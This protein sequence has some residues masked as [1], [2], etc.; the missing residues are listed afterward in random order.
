MENPDSVRVG[1]ACDCG[2]EFD[3]SI[4]GKDLEAMDF[5]CPA[6]GTIDRFQPDQIAEIVARYERAKTEALKSAKDFLGDAL[7]SATRGKKGITYR[8]S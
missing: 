5:T 1:V 7:A 4:A 2:H 6:C 8:G 3:V